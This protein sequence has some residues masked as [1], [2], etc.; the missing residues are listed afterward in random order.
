MTNLEPLGPS[1]H[2]T[3][4][5]PF[6]SPGPPGLSPGSFGHHLVTSATARSLYAGATILYPW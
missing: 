1:P 4:P 5:M 2:P 6:P 3:V